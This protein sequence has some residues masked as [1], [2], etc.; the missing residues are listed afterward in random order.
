MTRVIRTSGVSPTRSR[1]DSAYCIAAEY[2]GG[3]S[4][5]ASS[6]GP[7]PSRSVPGGRQPAP[8]LGASPRGSSVARCAAATGPA[9]SVVQRGRRSGAPRRVRRGDHGIGNGASSAQTGEARGRS[10]AGED[11]PAGTGG[12]DTAR[13]VPPSTIGHDRAHRCAARSRRPRDRA[14]GRCRAAS[15]GPVSGNRHRTAPAVERGGGRR[16]GARRRRRARRRGQIGMTPPIRPEDPAPP[17][18][19]EDGRG[20][21]R[22]RPSRG[23]S[24]QVVGDDERIDPGPMRQPRGD[25]AT[26]GRARRRRAAGARARRP[27]SGTRRRRGRCTADS[28]EQHP[29]A[30]ATPVRRRRSRPDRLGRPSV[31]RRD[32]GGR[33]AAAAT[34]AG[35][36][37]GADGPA[38]RPSS[39]WSASTTGPRIA[40]R[41]VAH[42]ARERRAP[43]A[44]PGRG[45]RRARRQAG[46][47]A[48][49]R[50][51]QDPRRHPPAEVELLG[52][53]HRERDD[54]RVRAQRDDRPAGP[55]RAEPAGRA[56][57][58]ALGHLDEDAAV[59]DDR[60]R[61]GDVLLD[62][63]P[64]RQTGSRPAEPVD[65]ALPPARGER[66]RGAAEEP[67]PRLGRAGRA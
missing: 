11:L 25:P 12:R 13:A 57:D 36:G 19:P 49:R 60:P 31:S 56:A 7:A 35:A 2:T 52:A 58:G 45:E 26:G 10:P 39:G 62:A 43:R 14:V 51:R 20:R 22:R 6:P 37:A 34:S 9:V 30:S 50:G 23:S 59:R 24:G 27:R 28:R 41:A 8:A 4:A 61:R 16:P 46:E 17:A 67:G 1:I 65:E 18:G 32:R 55:E 66:R 5:A 47:G 63:D 53:G 21:R 3:P 33:A 54:R 48:R 29:V 42:P 15:P 38:G 64:P 40:A 44:M